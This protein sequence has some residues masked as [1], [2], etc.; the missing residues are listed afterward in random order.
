MKIQ[1]KD[2]HVDQR[3]AKG[4]VFRTQTGWTSLNGE[5]RKAP[6]SLEEGQPAYELGMYTLGDG[7]F[8]FGDYGRLMLGRLELVPVPGTGAASPAA[9]AR[10][11]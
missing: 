10:A 8:Y 4:Y 5:V 2:L 1:V 3:S 9:A 6:I 7:S 11:G